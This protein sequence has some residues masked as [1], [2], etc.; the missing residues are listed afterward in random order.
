MQLKEDSKQMQEKLIKSI[1]EEKLKNTSIVEEKDKCI[2]TLRQ[3]IISIKKL[4]SDLDNKLK[5]SLLQ[6][7]MKD[8]INIDNTILEHFQ[9]IEVYK[10]TLTIMKKRNEIELNLI[11]NNKEV[12]T[13]F[14]KVCVSVKTSPI[15]I[16]N[17]S[18]KI[19]NKENVST[20][21]NKKEKNQ[22]SDTLDQSKNYIFQINYLN[23]KIFSQNFSIEEY[24]RKN[25][26]L[27]MEVKLLESKLIKMTQENIELFNRRIRSKKEVS[28]LMSKINN[29]SKLNKALN[30]NSN[31]TIKEFQST[32]S[33][34]IYVNMFDELS[35]IKQF[36]SEI[37]RDIVEI[38]FSTKRNEVHITPEKISLENKIN[39]V[40]LRVKEKIEDYNEE[41]LNNS[42]RKEDLIISKS[43]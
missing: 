21:L 22:S 29:F 33:D 36:L 1:E 2:E 18:F 11:K 13:D 43:I 5:E 20:I 23:E 39:D 19:I 26:A 17:Q 6:L 42:S 15:K 9:T 10:R 14:S 28:I 8:T 12:Q 25:E 31:R 4:N 27:E 32:I 24:I 16:D 37:Y 30:K 38:L 40:I 7:E 41:F 35:N 34:L 3:E